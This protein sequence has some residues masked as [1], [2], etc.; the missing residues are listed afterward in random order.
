[1]L[2]RETVPLKKISKGKASRIRGYSHFQA[3]IVGHICMD[4]YILKKTVGH[5]IQ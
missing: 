4:V 2:H 1:M 5:K 3:L